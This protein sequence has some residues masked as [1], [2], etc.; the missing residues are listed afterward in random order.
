M[1][2]R[3]VNIFLL[4][5]FVSV[6]P[7]FLYIY[8]P[9]SPLFNSALQPNA[10]LQEKLCSHQQQLNNKHDSH[11]SWKWTRQNSK[12][13]R[14]FE[15]TNRMAET[16]EIQLDATKAQS[17]THWLSLTSFS[18]VSCIDMSSV[19]IWGADVRLLLVGCC[20]KWSGH[21]FSPLRSTSISS[22]AWLNSAQ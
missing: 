7:F 4:G 12:T 9:C 5:Y 6:V 8:G 1:L 3:Y 10:A 22:T 21:G 15:S 11:K 17:R 2:G 19:S 16:K 14:V 20:H 13:Q 18:Q